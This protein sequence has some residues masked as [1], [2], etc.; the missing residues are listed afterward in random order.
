MATVRRKKFDE[1]KLVLLDVLME[2]IGS[3][4]GNWCNGESKDEYNQKI[5]PHF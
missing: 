4:A 3:K 1:G 5:S 2:G